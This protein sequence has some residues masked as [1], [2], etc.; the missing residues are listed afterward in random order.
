MMIALSLGR[1]K[2]FLRV[3]TSGQRLAHVACTPFA[4]DF[5]LRRNKSRC[6][7]SGLM[8]CSKEACIEW[9]DHNVISHNKAEIC[10]ILFKACDVCT[11][12][13]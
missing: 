12:R 6:A 11:P 5:S 2:P 1:S 9:Q 8:H 13:S 3:P 10:D 4:T 7:S